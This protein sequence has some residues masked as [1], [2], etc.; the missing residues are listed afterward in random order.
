MSIRAAKK[1]D[2]INI[3]NLVASLSHCYLKNT[4]SDL[5]E[6]FDQTLTNSAFSKRIEDT[7]YSNFVY[8]IE[9]EIIGY[10]AIK[11]C[12]YLFHLFVS[13]KH[14][15]EGLSRELW[16]FAT[17]VC[18]SNIYTLRSSLY[19]IPVYRKFGFIESGPTGEKDGIGFQPM[20]LRV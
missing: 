1:N 14:Q 5:P 17:K 15:G 19:A 4:G 16:E 8:E 10:I 20:E 2:V 18:V 13:E 7:D 6:W 11:G 3:S 12:S 9:G